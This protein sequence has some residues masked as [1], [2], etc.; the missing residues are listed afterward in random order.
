MCSFRGSYANRG[1]GTKLRSSDVA[2][3]HKLDTMNRFL[4]GLFIVFFW[5]DAGNR[6]CHCG[7]DK[8]DKRDNYC[9]SEATLPKTVL[10][11]GAFPLC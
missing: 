9:V 6:A 7:W 3:L 8:T 4:G 2:H 5:E 1:N 10:R 11:F